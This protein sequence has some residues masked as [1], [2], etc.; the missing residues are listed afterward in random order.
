LGRFLILGPS[1]TISGKTLTRHFSFYLQIHDLTT[2]SRNNIPH[3]AEIK[4]LLTFIIVLLFREN[5]NLLQPKIIQVHRP[6]CLIFPTPPHAV[7]PLPRLSSRT[8]KQTTLIR[9]IYAFNN[10]QQVPN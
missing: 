1:L 3:Y 5:S 7:T 2:T 10:Y 4:V 9:P 8:K 6:W